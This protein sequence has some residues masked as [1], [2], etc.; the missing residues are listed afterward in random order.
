MIKNYDFIKIMKT[1]RKY[2]FHEDYMSPYC[3]PYGCYYWLLIGLITHFY[4][5]NR[6]KQIVRFEKV[7]EFIYDRL[8][9]AG[10]NETF[11]S[12]FCGGFDSDLLW[13]FRDFLCVLKFLSETDSDELKDFIF[14]KC[15][16]RIY[17]F[18][19]I[20]IPEDGSEIMKLNNFFDITFITVQ[21]ND[22]RGNIQEE[23]KAVFCKTNNG[24]IVECDK[25]IFYSDWEEENENTNT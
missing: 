11:R 5:P 2:F 14:L 6:K 25:P 20:K 18:Q 3:E 9:D 12:S 17:T 4:T 13:T 22:E 21:D 16:E 7:E 10:Y 23:Y 1:F 19:K 24:E 15:E 8:I